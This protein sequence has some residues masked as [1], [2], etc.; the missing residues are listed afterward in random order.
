VREGGRD[1]RRESQRERVRTGG[2]GGWRLMAKEVEVVEL[3][4]KV[5]VET[6]SR[7]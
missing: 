7:F 3:R 1:R 6:G 2:V 5:E 4:A